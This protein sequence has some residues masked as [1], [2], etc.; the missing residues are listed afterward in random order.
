MPVCL[1]QNGKWKVVEDIGEVEQR[2][3]LP[4]EVNYLFRK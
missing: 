4:A 1:D 3:F 2:L